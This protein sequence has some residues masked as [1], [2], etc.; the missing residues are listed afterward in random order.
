MKRQ[1]GGASAPHRFEVPDRASLVREFSIVLTTLVF[2]SP[3][4]RGRRIRGASD[5]FEPPF[6]TAAS[7]PPQDRLELNNL[8]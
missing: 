1:L 6:V 8:Y 4:M 5:T 3:Q 2:V 7:C